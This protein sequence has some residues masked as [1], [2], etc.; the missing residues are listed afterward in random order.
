MHFIFYEV[1]LCIPPLSYQITMPD[2]CYSLSLLK[3]D[4]LYLY[5]PY[6]I[7]SLCTVTYSVKKTNLF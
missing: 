5:F 3:M 4:D 7:L 6:N 1:Y 2:Y